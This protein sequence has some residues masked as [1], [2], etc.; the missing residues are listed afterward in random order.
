[1]TTTR[2][3]FVQAGLALAAGTAV[4]VGCGGGTATAVVPQDGSAP[5]PEATASPTPK[6]ILVL[7]GTGFLGPHV[8]E[9]AL[10]RGHTLTLFNRGKT[11]AELFPE[12]E[13]LHGDRDGHLEALVGR[14]WDAVV[15]T[16]G[17]VPRLVKASAELLAP[18]VDQYVF[19]SSISAYADPLAAHANESAPLATMPDPSVEDGQFYGPLKALCEQ[20]AERAMPGRVTNVRPGLIVGPGDPTDRFTYWPARVARGGEVLAPGDGTDPGQVVDG[21]DLAAFLVRA[22]E[23]G[24]FGVFNAVGPATTMTMKDMLGACVTAAGAAAG[25]L[26]WVDNAFLEQQDV[27]PWVELPVWTGGDLGFATIDAAKAI[28]K[29]LTFRPIVETAK[30][31][32]AW[33]NGLP[34]E[35][36]AAPKAGLAPAKEAAVLAAWKARK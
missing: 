21:R 16:S 1:M 19:I 36:R 32:L 33:W 22:I 6:K 35:R 18:S 4:G 11:H 30:D 29:G 13:K 15:D 3:E 2:R 20:A 31:T 26:T 10:A 24:T 28:A 5:A 34:A 14:R 7:G 25:T 17:Y 23:D 12:L 8:V 27:H 9:A